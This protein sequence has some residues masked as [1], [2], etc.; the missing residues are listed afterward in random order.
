MATRSASICSQTLEDNCLL[1]N[2]H[3]VR[4]F[5]CDEVVE[6]IKT[7]ILMDTELNIPDKLSQ[8]VGEEYTVIISEEDHLCEMC[9]DLIKRLDQ[10]QSYINDIV[11]TLSN[12]LN[13]KY[14]L[15]EE[16]N[17]QVFL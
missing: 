10:L 5:I 7:S 9:N 17:T 4:C 6:S 8:L 1:R 11:R 15:T 14:G 2:E 16:T 3:L 13:K 12:H